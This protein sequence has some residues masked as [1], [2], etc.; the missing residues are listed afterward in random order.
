MVDLG[1]FLDFLDNCKGF[2]RYLQGFGVVLAK[3]STQRRIRRKGFGLF[4]FLPSDNEQREYEGGV[5][6]CERADCDG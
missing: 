6:P 4:R 1:E 2:S 5:N 3:V